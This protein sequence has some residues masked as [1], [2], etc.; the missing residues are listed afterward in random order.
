MTDGLEMPTDTN[1]VVVH[2]G[3]CLEVLRGLPDGC[4]DAVITDPPY[5]TEKTEWDHSVDGE[6]FAQCLRVSRGYCLFFYSNTRLWHIL[7]VLR[8]LGTDTWV[9]PWKKSN[10]MG[11]ER[12]F[13]PQWVPVVCAYRG[14]L[15]F[16]GQDHIDCPIVPHDFDHPTPKPVKVVRWLVDKATSPGDVVLDPFA[17]SGTTGVACLME[18]RR[19]ILIER[20]PAYCDIIR[21]RL[22]HASGTGKGSLFA[23]AGS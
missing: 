17:G 1:P 19:A 4:V 12:R 14:N 2:N 8:S 11:F 16:W 23:T 22:A 5:G 7:G 21:R 20:E 15:P 10:A 13:A 18:N 3:D 6:V 9:I